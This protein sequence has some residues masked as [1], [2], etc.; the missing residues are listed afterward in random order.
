[1]SDERIEKKPGVQDEDT[2]IAS[3]TEPEEYIEQSESAEPEGDIAAASEPEQ[4]PETADAEPVAD[5][6]VETG[7]EGIADVEVPLEEAADE[8]DLGDNAAEPGADTLDEDEPEANA[9]TA[10]ETVAEEAAEEQPYEGVLPEFLARDEDGNFG[11]DPEPLPEGFEVIDGGVPADGSLA[12][13]PQPDVAPAPAPA[14]AEPKGPSAA[15]TFAHNAAEAASTVGT[16][17]QQGV[18]AVREMR[19]AKRAHAEARDML[20]E[21]EERIASQTEE[22]A[23]RRDVTERYP[24]IVN[25]Q[26]TRKKGAQAAANAAIALQKTITGQIETLKKQLDDMKASDAA[27]EKRL[28][29]ALEAAERKE[30]EARESANRMKRRLTDAQRG[31]EKAREAGASSVETAQHAVEAAT[32]RLNTLREEY[33]EIQRNPSAN[34]AAYSIRDTELAAEIAD[35]TEE[36]RRANEELPRVQADAEAS[37]AAAQEAVAESERPIAEAKEAFRA[38]TDQTAAARDALD[39]A[40]KDASSRQKALKSKISDQERDLKEQQEAQASAEAEIAEADRVIADAASI[41]DNPDVTERIASALAADTAE[42]DDQLQQVQS[43]AAA[44]ASVRELTRESRMR[45][46]GII[47]VAV[48]II[49]IIVTIV[50]F[51]L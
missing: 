14:P 10:G 16:Y 1:M 30:E 41:H 48:V 31:V 7:D 9:E 3:E 28:K 2:T 17:I 42:R 49:L 5:E 51:I 37:L 26:T 8:A 20:E 29:S 40:R 27:T 4:K 46:I 23:Y 13:Q 39:A 38:V 25:E 6:V 15:E 19:H 36:L 33:A 18:G 44:E 45:F 32:A 22:L 47:T 21:L 50:L 35:A 34:S 12:A 11:D 43:L 24:E